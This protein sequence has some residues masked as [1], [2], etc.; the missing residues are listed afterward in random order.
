MQQVYG[1]DHSS[2]IEQVVEK[3]KSKVH[4]KWKNYSSS[5]SIN[6]IVDYDDPKHEFACKRV[7][8]TCNTCNA[9]DTIPSETFK[10]RIAQTGTACRECSGL[11]IGSLLQYEIRNFIMNCGVKIIDN[12][13]LSDGRQIDVYCPDKNIG[14]EVNGL[15]W[16]SE[17][18]NIDSKYHLSKTE[19]AESDS[20]RL[21]H[22]FEDEWE[23]Q[24]AIVKSRILNLLNLVSKTIDARKCSVREVD[25]RVEREFLENNHIQGWAPSSIK[26]GLFYNECLVSLMTFSRPSLSKGI[27]NASSNHWELLRYCSTLDTVVRGG[28]GKLLQHFIRTMNPQSIIS[29]SDRRW[30]IGNLYE[31]LGFSNKGHTRPNYWYVHKHQSKRIHRF[32]MRKNSNDDTN[33]TEWQNR[34]NQGY[35]RIWDCGSTKWLWTNQKKSQ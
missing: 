18:N 27:R 8:F 4:D 2:K 33:L 20:I 10:W 3:R 1:V 25:S 7:V 12:Y 6:D 31:R 35:V 26:L 5:L 15:Y 23:H 30:S 11:S 22:I 29:Y 17:A 34:A 13:R 21:I 24:Q 14:F 28:A 19:I 32:R 16:H 9:S